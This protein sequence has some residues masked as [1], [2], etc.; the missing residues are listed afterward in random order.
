MEDGPHKRLTF[1]HAAETRAKIFRKVMLLTM[2][3]SRYG[4]VHPSRMKSLRGH[5]AFPPVLPQRALAQEKNKIGAPTRVPGRTLSSRPG[6]SQLQS[7]T[8]NDGKFSTKV[9]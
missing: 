2:S 7:S 8:R 1:C 9:S 5:P 4:D 6:E 3:E